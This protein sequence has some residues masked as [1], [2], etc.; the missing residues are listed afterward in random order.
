MVDVWTEIKIRRPCEE[1]SAYAANPDNAPEWYVNIRSAEWLTPKPLAVGS[2]IA[3]QARF[4][5]KTLA[6]VYRIAAYEPGRLLVMETADGPFPMETTYTW[7][8]MDGHTT[9]MTLRNR[10]KPSGFSAFL[11]PMMAFM[12]RRANEKDLKRIKALLEA[13]PVE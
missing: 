10:G 11:T 8:A 13:R 4:L 5:G 6:Y 3:F 7:E 9:R 1:V 12:M 2:R